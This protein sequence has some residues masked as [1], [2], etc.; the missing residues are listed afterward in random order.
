MESAVAALPMPKSLSSQQHC[1]LGSRSLVWGCGA[2]V[3]RLRVLGCGVEAARRWMRICACACMRSCVGNLACMLG[4]SCGVHGVSCG[5]H[6]R[7]LCCAGSQR[8]RSLAV[9]AW[10][11]GARGL[12]RRARAQ[13]GRPR[14]AFGQQCSG[15]WIGRT[16]W[17]VGK[18]LL[19]RAGSREGVCSSGDSPLR[20]NGR[21]VL[22]RHVWNGVQGARVGCAD[23]GQC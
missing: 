16:G 4:V 14:R 22:R 7:V 17:G 21:A 6:A 3:F 8:R 20:S 23:L 9:K 10:Q 11:L 13:G 12:G 1:R 2:Q 15:R 19:R 18:K 5:V